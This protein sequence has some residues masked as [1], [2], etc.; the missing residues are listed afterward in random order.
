MT[1]DSR[2]YEGPLETRQRHPS[3]AESSQ[4]EVETPPVPPSPPPRPPANEQAPQEQD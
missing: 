4:A 1:D 2:Q 3:L